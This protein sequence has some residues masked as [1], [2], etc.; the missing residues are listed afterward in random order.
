MI[1][2]GLEEMNWQCSGP[3]LTE[4]SHSILKRIVACLKKFYY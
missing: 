3:F 2:V 4:Q 1:D